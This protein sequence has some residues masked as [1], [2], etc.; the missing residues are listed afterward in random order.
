MALDIKGTV[1][2]LA[3]NLI[4]TGRTKLI[5]T[6]I[7]DAI[8]LFAVYKGFVE[9]GWQTVVLLAFVPIVTIVYFVFRHLEQI[10]TVQKG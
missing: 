7:C 10:N 8:L 9:T 1:L 4:S 5:A 6:I 2:G 3:E